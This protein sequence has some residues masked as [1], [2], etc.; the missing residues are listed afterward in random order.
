MSGNPSSSRY[1]EQRYREVLSSLEL[2][3]R[4]ARDVELRLRRAVAHVAMAGLGSDSE[5]NRHLQKIRSHVRS[6]GELDA[7]DQEIEGLRSYMRRQTDREMRLPPQSEGLERLLRRILMQWLQLLKKHDPGDSV[8]ASL[9]TRLPSA[10]RGELVKAATLLEQRMRDVKRTDHDA[11]PRGMLAHVSGYFSGR[12][13][14]NP[15]AV[16]A[17]MDRLSG[18]LDQARL[19]AARKRLDQ[20]G[21]QAIVAVCTDLA[22]MVEEAIDQAEATAWREAAPAPPARANQAS[23]R[24]NETAGPHLPREP[25]CLSPRLA[26]RVMDA[27]DLPETLVERAKGLVDSA[28]G[29]FT[30]INGISR[31]LGDLA[32][33]LSDY[34]ASVTAE[35]EA[36]R[37]FLKLVLNRLSELE[38]YFG[39]ERKHR[40]RHAKAG[41]KVD[42]A[43]ASDLDRIRKVIDQGPELGKL[44]KAIH[45]R[46]S[47]ISH[48]LDRRKVLEEQAG[49][50][51]EQ[52]LQAMETR[53]QEMEN[54]TSQLRQRLAQ[55]R[56]EA[57]TDNLTGLPNRHSCERRMNYESAR[58]E[59]YGRPFCLAVCDLD[60]FKLINDELGHRGG[61]VALVQFADT[62]RDSL[63]ETDHAA[64]F[65]GEEFVILLPETSLEQAR[66]WAERLRSRIAESGFSYEEAR[67]PLTLSIGLAACQPNETTSDLYQ[68]ADQAMYEAKRQG[69]NRVVTAASDNSGNSDLAD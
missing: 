32:E 49:Q 7:I 13:S 56:Q 12:R 17:L 44:S 23:P 48:H 28:S 22:E 57:N 59:R 41:E 36:L 39:N 9:Q 34:Q 52:R 46:L 6:E 20:E 53:V 43:L 67:Y 1:W 24:S 64:R 55:A 68:R 18:R 50:A 62:L 19:A 51:A 65:G 25:D 3:G 10:S 54:E 21:S 4:E 11:P 2:Q 35:R 29:Q 33:L 45:E 27:I 38:N 8:L 37:N 66:C 60:E 42:A 61:D 16:R 30:D 5:L 69:R 58:F 15:K 47:R 14:A 63:R 31:W 40:E 26:E